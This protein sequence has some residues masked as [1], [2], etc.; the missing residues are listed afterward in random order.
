MARFNSTFRRKI[1]HE[2]L[3][4]S[5]ANYFD[6]RAFLAW[7][8]PRQEHQCWDLFFGTDDAEAAE[9]WRLQQVRR[10]VSG[11]RI[12]IGNSEIPEDAGTVSVEMHEEGAGAVVPA[13]ISVVSA[14]PYGGGYVGFDPS[15]AGQVREFARQGATALASWLERYGGICK[16]AG[17]DAS[18]VEALAG[19]LAAAGVDPVEQE[20]EPLFE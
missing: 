7:L 19:K 12:T 17:V 16:L 10:F 9:K 20:D 2:Y 6:P 8:E 13:F 5:G 15:D 18:S 11:L 14:R 3:Q 1:I 4:E